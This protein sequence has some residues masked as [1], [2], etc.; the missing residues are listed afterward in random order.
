MDVVLLATLAGVLFGALAVAV[1]VA[2]RRARDPEAGAFVCA[3]LG[4]LVAAAVA[5]P[6]A[7]PGVE[8]EGLWA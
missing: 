7:A 1:R 3:L 6:L 8:T 2:L 5:L 4:F